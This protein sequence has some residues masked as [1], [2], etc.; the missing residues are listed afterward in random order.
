MN[1][2]T[3]ADFTC[4]PA[5]SQ[6]PKDFYN[7]LEV[8]IDAVFHPNLN[9]LSFLQEGHRFEFEQPNDPQ[10][11]L[12]HRGIVF[13]EMK[14]VL[15]S[16]TA[17]LMEAM[18]EALFPNL[19]YGINSGGD[20]K[21]IPK[22]SYLELC[23]FHQK[24]YLPNHCLYFFYGNLPLEDHLDFIT[25]HALKDLAKVAPLSPISI[26][27]RFTKPKYLE[28][29][30]PISP[31]EDVSDK[32]IISYG[33][34]T[35]H[36]LKQQ[37]V[38]AL[39][40][41]EIVLMDTDASPLK[42][43]LLRSGL[44]KQVSASMDVD[45]SEIPIILILRGCQAEDADKLELVIQ[46]TLNEVIEKGIPI[47]QVENAMHQLE[48][49]RSEITGN[50][51]PFGLS[52]F[53]RSALLK[54]HGGNAE[55]GLMIHSL[56]HQVRQNILKDPQYLTDLIK[57]YFID[58]THFVRLVMNPSRDLMAREIEEERQVLDERKKELTPGEIKQILQ[59][60]EALADF[61]KKQEDDDIEV[62][63]KIALSD[64]PAVSRYFT[65]HEETFGPLKVFHH[66]CFTNNIVYADL[67]YDLP[68]IDENELSLVRLFTTL[69]SQMG[70]GNRKYAE[71][72]DYMQAHTGGV[73]A[74]LSLNM[75]VTDPDQF[76][77][78]IA[79]RGKALHHKAVKLFP[80]ITDMVEKIDF[81]DLERLKEV[82]LK[83][84]T[85]LQSSFTQSS[86]RYAIN[87][88]ASSLDVPSK[89]SNDWYGLNYYKYIKE[90]AENIEATLL[91]LSRQ[92]Q[93][94]HNRVFGL[95]NPHLVITCTAAMYEQLKR[96]QFY[97]MHN[98]PAR[99]STPWREDFSL[100]DIPDTGYVIASPV[101]FISHIFKTIPYV[102][103]DSAAL[104]IASALF[105]NLVLHQ[106]IREQ[107]GAYGGGAS[108]NTL[109]GHFY[110]YSYRDPNISS[111]IKAFEDSIKAI[112]GGG[113]E[114]SE[115][116]EAKLEIIQSLDTPV[117]PG[118]R[119]DLAY[120][121]KKEGKTPEIRQAFRNRLLEITKDDVVEAVKRYIAPVYPLGKTVV[122]AGKELL[123][124][125]NEVLKNEGKSILVLETI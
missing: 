15:T 97:G 123:E 108:H 125:E 13:N 47:E 16:S 35:C 67:I 75:Q 4:Y 20:P 91:P 117:A 44:C 30:Y 102:D 24:F 122:F 56:F 6:V 51:S 72:L 27:P 107:G 10:S 25:K 92:L 5:A 7:L 2:L 50:H 26:Q 96:N 52:L 73:G 57:K 46:N 36:I 71:T 48:F 93:E 3:G 61:Q 69:A 41:L 78:T 22:L 66:N 14:G 100:N 53:M 116:E 17:R 113:F 11:N 8:Y 110:F 45:M 55:D 76:H 118:S 86:L 82:L 79:I 49:F 124:T 60:T 104:A 77:P 111:S 18:N 1:A 95:K 62:L 89:I 9:E 106:R 64:V 114:E 40:I 32:T 99:L 29:E 33:W 70:C 112:G 37:E 59:K 81:T 12:E 109:S 39:S 115:L 80:F 121:W 120:Y 42:L 28:S 98:L 85:S 54:Q 74:Y 65:L 68:K 34:L 58:N 23:A 38:L 63:P 103:P 21:D 88:G 83:Q 87:L 101:A 119:G 19:T 94:I 84:Y 43:A 105:D 31:E 90:I